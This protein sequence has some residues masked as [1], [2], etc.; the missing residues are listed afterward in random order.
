MLS[1]CGLLKRYADLVILHGAS[2]SVGAGEAV[3]VMG[4]SGSGKSTLL[5]CLALLQRF[6]G[7]EVCHASHAYGPSYWAAENRSPLRKNPAYPFLTIVFQQ[8]HLWPHLDLRT[9][10]FL[11][12]SDPSSKPP[13]SEFEAILGQLE[14]SHLLERFPNECSAGQCQRVALARGLLRR[15]RYILLD[16]VTSALDR[17]MSNK[18]V[19]ILR[20]VK[21]RGVGLLIVTHDERV[22]ETIADRVLL[23]EAG[24]LRNFGDEGR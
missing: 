17:D 5:R 22:F 1:C 24:T 23:L 7:G 20:S 2:L 11:Q 8:Y 21:M 14:I 12:G 15:T 3:V 13:R 6:E 4:S 19:E 9:N 10:L 16:E 18:V